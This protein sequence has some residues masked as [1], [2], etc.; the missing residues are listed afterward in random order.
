MSE[1]LINNIGSFFEDTL[2][3][4]KELSISW[5]GGEPLLALDTI[6]KI[7]DMFKSTILE[8][9]YI[10]MNQPLKLYYKI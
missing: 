2:S 3:Q 7:T 6:E 10:L 9:Y 5:Y 4:I 1:S 8:E